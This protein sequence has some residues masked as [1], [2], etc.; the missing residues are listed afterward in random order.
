MWEIVSFPIP[1][2]RVNTN[3]QRNTTAMA[4]LLLALGVLG[5][6]TATSQPATTQAAAPEPV[7]AAEVAPVPSQAPAQTTKAATIGKTTK[8]MVRASTSGLPVKDNAERGTRCIEESRSFM[9]DIVGEESLTGQVRETFF[10]FF[11]P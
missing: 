4:A 5:E 9:A 10:F 7:A 3:Q 1:Q 6:A 2:L 11:F 8:Q